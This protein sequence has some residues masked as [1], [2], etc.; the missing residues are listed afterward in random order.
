M[1][2]VTDR[3][4]AWLGG[5]LDAAAAAAL[6]SHLRE[7]GDCRR[8][9]DAQRA[10]WNAMD[11]APVPTPAGR[12]WPAVRERT[13]GARAGG[14]FFGGSPAL[15]AALA[16]ATLAVG[17]LGG[18]LT[19]DLSGTRASQAEDDGSLAAVW[20]EDSTWHDASGGGLAESW[21]ALASDGRTAGEAGG[22]GGTR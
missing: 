8:E 22:K 10:T 3:L 4:A 15:R 21:L 20:L 11:A 16:V 1:K 2:H 13:F 7:C 17:V 5:E 14:W 9:A 18:R 12:V 19:G 6:E